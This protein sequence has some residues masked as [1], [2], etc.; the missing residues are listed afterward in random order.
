M[1]HVSITP[2]VQATAS[3]AEVIPA[4]AP[5]VVAE[6]AIVEVAVAGAAITVAAVVAILVEAEVAAVAPMVA[7]VTPADMGASQRYSVSL[8]AS[9]KSLDAG[10]E[11]K[12]RW[13]GK[14]APGV[15]YRI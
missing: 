6:A 8:M 11:M 4:A 15:G 14:S 13:Y 12:A 10:G 3:P 9:W 7:E 2:R 5:E 1:P